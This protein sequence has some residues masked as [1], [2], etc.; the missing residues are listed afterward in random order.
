M[1]GIFALPRGAGS[2]S[3]AL[4]QRADLIADFA[5]VIDPD[6]LRITCEEPLSF[7]ALK[8]LERFNRGEYF[9]AHDLL[10]IAW[11]E[12]QSPGRD[13]YRA[14]LQV[15]IAYYQILQGNYN[16]AAKMFLR[17]RKWL[18]PLPDFCRGINIDKLRREARAVHKELLILGADGIN[19]IDRGLM[20]RIEYQE[21]N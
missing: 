6:E 1:S 3:Q 12:D 13:L 18:D 11:K 9:E 21:Q 5:Q 14:I 16:G 2:G 20:K 19:D 15:S 4:A 17:M 7:Y 8:G 10:E